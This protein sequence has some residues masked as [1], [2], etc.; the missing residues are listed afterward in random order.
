VKLVVE[1]ADVGVQTIETPLFVNKPQTLEL[2]DLASNREL[3]QQVADVSGGKL[4][5]PDQLE[6]LPPLLLHRDL[7]STSRE[8][9]ELWDHWLILVAFFGLLTTEWVIR[10]LNG[11]P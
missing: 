10:K 3:L 5:L 11:L 4:F 8:D 7:H 1:G 9:R 2:S 6:D